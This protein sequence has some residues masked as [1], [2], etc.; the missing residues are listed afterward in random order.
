[1][2]VREITITNQLGLHARASGALVRLA[3]TFQAEITVAKDGTQVNAKSIMGLLLLAAANGSRIEIAAE[4][5]DEQ[6]A[7]AA[8]EAL[9]RRKFHEE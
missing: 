6:E 4:G 3:S 1:V 7:L 2:I 8:I 9:V 5:E